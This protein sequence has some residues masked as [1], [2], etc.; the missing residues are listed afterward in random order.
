M[1]RFDH[2]NTILH[3]LLGDSRLKST[4]YQPL[5]DKEGKYVYGQRPIIFPAPTI[6]AVELDS[7]LNF[8]NKTGKPPYALETEYITVT[9]EAFPVFSH[10]AKYLIK[11][12]DREYICQAFMDSDDYARIQSFEKAEDDET[13]K[14]YL[15]SGD[16]AP[17]AKKNKGLES[18]EP[19][20][21]FFIE[22][23]TA[24][25]EQKLFIWTNERNVSVKFELH[26]LSEP[27]IY[28]GLSTQNPG[29][30]GTQFL[31]P[32]VSLDDEVY[33]PY[34]EYLRVKIDGNGAFNIDRPLLSEATINSVTNCAEITNQD[35]IL[36]PEAVG[37]ED[38]EAQSGTGWGNIGWFGLFYGQWNEANTKDNK[39][40][41][42]WGEIR[43][44]NG[45][46]G[47][48]IKYHEVPVIRTSSLVISIQ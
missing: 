21:P 10:K 42:L 45:K 18:W 29:P 19:D 22:T 30:D 47:V 9:N 1:L 8:N 26:A 41:F 3:G 43:D 33:K 15:G 6:K 24:K 4:S 46:Q 11:W 38:K 7:S 5:L 35:M 37:I 34:P 31:E 48:E 2:S 40:P 17:D 39:V 32:G 23:T 16:V 44:A 27:A 25:Q 12:N 36:F 28:L 14:I 13:C 20:V